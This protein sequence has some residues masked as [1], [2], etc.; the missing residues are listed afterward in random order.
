[1]RY[2]SALRWISDADVVII[3]GN[4]SIHLGK[5]TAIRWPNAAHTYWLV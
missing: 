4:Y 5:L 3:D 1:M 2:R